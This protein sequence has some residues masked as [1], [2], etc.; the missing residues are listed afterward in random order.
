MSAAPN[1]SGIKDQFWKKNCLPRM[2]GGER[3]EWFYM[4][5][6]SCAYADECSL[7]RCLCSLVL[8]RP[9][10]STGAHNVNYGLELVPA[11]HNV[12]LEN[13]NVMGVYI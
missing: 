2:G 6:S 9:W 10:T 12:N 13:N 8:N 3:R 7:T 4:Q 11:L 5:P 1:L